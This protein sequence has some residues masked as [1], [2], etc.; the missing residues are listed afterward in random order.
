MALV[1]DFHIWEENRGNKGRGKQ[2]KGKRFIVY[3]RAK[4]QTGNHM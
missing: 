3:K 1:S 2:A 4:A